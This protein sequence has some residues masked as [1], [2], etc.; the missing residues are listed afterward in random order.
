[1][2]LNKTHNHSVGQPGGFV[3]IGDT[4]ILKETYAR[5][6]PAD[7]QFSIRERKQMVDHGAWKIAARLWEVLLEADPIESNNTTRSS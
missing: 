5:A 2:I 3:V 7:P 1:L 6:T 4:S